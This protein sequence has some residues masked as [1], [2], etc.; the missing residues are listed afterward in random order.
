MNFILTAHAQESV[1]LAYDFVDTINQ[2]VLVPLIQLMMAIALIVF[3]WGGFQ[4]VRGSN[5]P[6]ARLEGR[7]HLLWGIIGFTVMVSAYAILT[8]AGNTVGV[9]LDEYN[10]V[11][12]GRPSDCTE[13]GPC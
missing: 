3:I 9:D 5:D 11:L 1:S 13:S 2:V 6:A 4:Y 10:P 8:V 12:H 7:R